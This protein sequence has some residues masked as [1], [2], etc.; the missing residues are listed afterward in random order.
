MSGRLQF[1]YEA[2]NRTTRSQTKAC[3]AKLSC[4]ICSL[5]T[6]YVA[7]TGNSLPTS[8]YNL[9]VPS[10]R[11]KIFQRQKTASLTLS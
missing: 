4:E 11:A 7:Q 5:A 6:C 8:R 2:L 1:T 3:I 10:S 9:S